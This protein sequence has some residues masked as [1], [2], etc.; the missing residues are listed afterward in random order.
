[1]CV[2]F[3]SYT[4]AISALLYRWIARDFVKRQWNPVMRET[5]SNIKRSSSKGSL[6][7]TF[8]KSFHRGRVECRVEIFVSIRG[9]KLRK[10][11]CPRKRIKRMVSIPGLRSPG[12]E[13]GF[14][15]KISKRVIYRRL[16][17]KRVE[18][19]ETPKRYILSGLKV[20]G[21][22]CKLSNDR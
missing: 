12:Q 9:E 13:T 22:L 1:M 17:N 19:V 6:R 20:E 21:I 7:V 16:F 18:I 4:I 8:R 15:M 14:L 10:F 3:L 11:F 5:C 2:P